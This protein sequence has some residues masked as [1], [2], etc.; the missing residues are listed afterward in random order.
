MNLALQ[1]FPSERGATIGHL[2]VDGEWECYTLEDLVREVKIP[3]E[4]AIP[5]G[6]YEVIVDVSP[7]FSRRAGHKVWL[8]RLLNVPG[9]EGVLIHP[10]NTADHTDG[11]ILPG[12]S[13]GQIDG[14][15]AVLG[16]QAAFEQLFAKIRYATRVTLEVRDAHPF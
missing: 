16:S 1:R 14:K 13:I 15:P 11:C 4:T 8:P 10:G 6:T 5:A 12:T 2:Y 9:Y 7:S 3:R